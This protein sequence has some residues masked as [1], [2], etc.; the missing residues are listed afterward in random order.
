MS[1]AAKDVPADFPLNTI[2]PAV[3]KILLSDAAFDPTG[4]WTHGYGVYSTP[5]GAARVG[6]LRLQR[7]AGP[8]QR[9]TLD[10]QYEKTHT[11]GKQQIAAKI[12]FPAKSPLSAPAEWSFQAHV[13]DNAGRVIEST[14]IRKSIA[15]ADGTLVVNDPTGAK[16]TPLDGEYA[17]SWALFD[18]V[19]RLPSQ[20]FAPLCFTLID[21]FDQVKPGH[22]LSY[23]TKTEATIRGAKH[24]LR[25]YDQLGRGVVPWV[26]WVDTP[27]RVVAAVSGIEVYVLEST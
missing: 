23:R 7:R 25:A 13:L 3:D 1:A 5:R 9:V 6:E 20:A 26:W 16:R 15:V 27:G 14:R 22:S 11:G 21:H 19:G 17:L 2:G 18:A 4:N 10:F 12:H 24:R 8:G